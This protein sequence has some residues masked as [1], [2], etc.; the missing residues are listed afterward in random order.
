M[1]YRRDQFY[2]Q[3]FILYINDLC[4]TSSHLKSILFA[5]D[6]SFVVDGSDLSEMCK[7]VSI[8][9]NKTSTWFKVNK[10]S[11]NISKTYTIFNLVNAICNE[12]INI[13]NVDINKVRCSKFLVVYIDCKL[14]WFEHVN[15]IHVNSIHV[16]SIHVNSIHVNSIHV[17]SI[18]AKIAKK[19]VG[20]ACS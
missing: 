5:G 12:N 14:R 7:E 6:T 19:S 2:C 1:V 13:D 8:E 17:N 11:L 16:N 15:S 9:L 4:K 3:L 20:N 10:L 18:H